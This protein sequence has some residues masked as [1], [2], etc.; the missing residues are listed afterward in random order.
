MVDKMDLLM[1][2]LSRRYQKPRKEVP[3]ESFASRD[4]RHRYGTANVLEPDAERELR[5]E[6]RGVEPPA[7]VVR[8]ELCGH[9]VTE[10]VART[11][12]REASV[13]SRQHQKHVREFRRSV[14][15]LVSRRW[16]PTL[17]CWVL[18]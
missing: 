6:M 16:N 14:G 1:D 7:K 18:D 9:D 10:A 11:R 8:A 17:E 3:L 15:A 12:R 13:A 5:R 2:R 4:S